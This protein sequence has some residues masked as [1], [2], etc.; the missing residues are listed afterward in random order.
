MRGGPEKG[1]PGKPGKGEGLPGKEG[2]KKDAGSTGPP[3]IKR[4]E[5]PPVPPSPQ[6]LDAVPD[7]D[8]RI[9]FGF[10]GQPW[11]EVL[12]WLARISRMSLDW[13]ELPG[14]Y[15][16][17]TT[18]RSYTVEEA[19]DLIN[20]HLLARGFTLL[21]NGE[22]LTVSSIAKI[23]PGMIPR[24]ALE[25]LDQRRPHEY[26]KVSFE[27]DW[28]MAEAAAEELKPMLSPNGKLTPLKTTNRL[29]AMDAV[30]NLR[31]ICAVL[32]QEQSLSGQERLVR[33]FVLQHARASDVLTQLE[34][35]LGSAKKPA[36]PVPMNPQQMEMM[37]Q[38][39]R[40]MAEQQ[41]QQMQ[42]QQR[43]A[44]PPSPAAK[45]DEEVNLVVNLRR[46][47]ILA[48]AP[49]D[50]MAI[51]EQ[52]IKAIAVPRD[53]R[54]SLITNP[55][56]MQ[57]YRLHALDPQPLVKTLQEIGE[58]DPSTRLEADSKNRAIIAYAS[59]ADHVVLRQ[60]I[61]RLDGSERKFEVIRLR[62]L[63][64]D[65][66]AGS[67][68]FMMAGQKEQEERPRY[69]FDYY[70][71]RRNEEQPQ[72]KFRVDADVEN[73]RLLLWA[74]EVEIQEV[75][76]LLVKLGEL[77]PEGGRPSTFRVLDPVP[78]EEAGELFERIRKAW[79]SLAPN[80][81][82]V[83]QESKAEERDKPP[84]L[85]QRPASPPVS[86]ETP[87]GAAVARSALALVAMPG[88]DPQETGP[89]PPPL[90]AA[91]PPGSAES[92]P[93]PTPRGVPDPHSLVPGGEAASPPPG[94]HRD[95]P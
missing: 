51:I 65:Y 29:E 77:P 4:P 60:L 16:N 5:K 76:N 1:A 41:Q 90:P 9:R 70:S 44:R 57:V 95:R 52:A 92:R 72:D 13:Q 32:K 39:A 86:R 66:V 35:L 10:R 47:S 8:G 25:E 45:R 46:N 68:E 67:I 62:R 56:R 27:L 33:E 88:A 23:D 74:N 71:P 85:P 87:A 37:Q 83:P 18:Q 20:W 48:N 49:P 50:K 89:A 28:L 93:S 12:D 31:Q 69:F 42:M 15:L 55:N 58:L 21:E 2:E 75:M 91:K 73:N 6:E 17:L 82:N 38:Q 59:L 78:E 22:L 36:M 11:P 63:A 53:R 3:V 80:P 84:E 19:R 64:A 34:T 7:K 43:G 30:E 81:L 94:E 61:D 14:D 26:V 79:P 24:V 54:D 40:M